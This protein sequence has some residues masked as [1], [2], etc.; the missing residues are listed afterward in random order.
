MVASILC[1][2]VKLIQIALQAP[3]S[4]NIS[5]EH[6][7]PW[8]GMRGYWIVQCLSA[9]ACIQ[10][11]SVF[12]DERSENEVETSQK[13]WPGRRWHWYRLVT[14][15]AYSRGLTFCC[16]ALT[17]SQASFPY[18]L[19]SSLVHVHVHGGWCCLANVC[20]LCASRSSM[21]SVF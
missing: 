16:F 9:G 13:L 6:T 7:W 1:Q 14:D 11:I 10:I 4:N 17:M 18:F 21:A 15:G 19:L 20:D 2:S 3:T 12:M 8:S 5:R